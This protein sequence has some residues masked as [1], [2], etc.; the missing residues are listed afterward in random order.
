MFNKKKKKEQR[1][2]ETK[3]MNTHVEEKEHLY[4][5]IMQI[6]LPLL[7]SYFVSFSSS[8]YI[9]LLILRLSPYAFCPPLVILDFG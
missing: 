4:S 6:T 5:N 2:R 1:G 8:S 7:F 3:K 9:Y